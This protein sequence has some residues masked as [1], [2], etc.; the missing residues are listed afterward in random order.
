[1][2]L[3]RKVIDSTVVACMLLA[4]TAIT[5]VDSKSV[6]P[7]QELTAIETESSVAGVIG[8]FADI[9]ASTEAVF[10]SVSMEKTQTVT[11]AA[12]AVETKEE[13]PQLTEEEKEWSNK[14]MANVEDALNVRTQ[15]DENAELAGKLHRGDRAEIVE[16]LSGWTHIVSGNVDGYVKTEYCLT[17]TDALNFAKEV[18]GE[19]ATVLTQG[20][21]IRQ[22]PSED[23]EVYASAYEG[24]KLT[25]KT[26]E[27]AQDGWVTVDYNGSIAYV[28]AEYVQTAIAYSAGITIEEEQEQIR[29]AEEEKAA[30]AAAQKKQAA[31][32]QNASVA[33]SVDEVTLLGAIIQ[34]EAGSEC[35]D[36][37]VAVG[38]VVMNRVR[39]G[40]FPSSI[41]GVIYQSGQFTPAGSGSLANRI[42]SG[43]SGTCIQAAQQ[44]LGGYDNTGGALYFRRAGAHAGTVIGNHV[45][46]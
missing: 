38:A 27:P 5:A 25:V 46:Y 20:L 45:F 39:S 29:K 4:I 18:C 22:N 10:G 11:V 6:V 35:Y 36:G 42:A 7:E 34:C 30:K 2:G 21:R 37:M 15:A 26:E 3:N 17:G 1:M 28:K 14:L 8:E 44:A 19:K 31:V 16:Q 33:A 9:Q 23:S 40:A 32:T 24:E 43:V 41:Q 12:A 13:E